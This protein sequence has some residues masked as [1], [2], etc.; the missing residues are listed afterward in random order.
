MNNMKKSFYIQKIKNNKNIIIGSLF[1]AIL[2]TLITYPGIW[3]SDSYSRY[4]MS[5]TIGKCLKMILNG[6]RNLINVSCWLT[7]VP[8]FFMEFFKVITGNIAAYTVFQAFMFFQATFLLCKKLNNCKKSYLKAKYIILALSP[9]IYCVSVYYEASILCVAAL[10]YLILLLDMIKINKSVFDKIIE[11]GLIIFF[12]FMMFGYRA[13]AFT[14]IP[15]LLFYIYKLKIDKKLKLLTTFSLMFGYLLTFLL[16]MFL[17]IKIMSSV[18][19]GFAWE[20]ISVIQHLDE[21]KKLNYLNYLDE[22]GGSGSTKEAL[23]ISTESSVNSLFESEINK[24]NLSKEGNSKIILSK[25]INLIIKEPLTYFKV[26][27]NFTLKT[28]GIVKKI[29]YAEYNYNRWN[30]MKK[31][32]FSDSKM[33]VLFVKSYDKFN[34]LFGFVIRRPWI[35]YL[36]TIL[37]IVASKKQKDKKTNYYLFI[38]MLSVFYYGAYIINTQSFEI[39]YFYPSLYLCFILDLSIFFN[40]IPI[41]MSKIKFRKSDSND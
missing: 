37:D 21:E 4:N 39:R 20:I 35:V 26:K 29:S 5:L 31:Y 11:F 14:V 25:Y 8:S 23:K 33:R 40:F 30:I 15:V 3:Y 27:G 32:N 6:Q 17:N 10:V 24:E 22:I 2:C 1:L 7:V 28:L 9:L 18:S 36:L 16:P 41:I 34:E 38:F 13:N 19:A 12:S